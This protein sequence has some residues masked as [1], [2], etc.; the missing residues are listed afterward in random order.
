MSAPAA[1]TG[2]RIALEAKGVSK[3]FGATRALRDV[4]LELR[5][6]GIHAADSG[7][8]T[9]NGVE[10][11][12][13]AQT[14]EL[15]RQA[16]L[17]FVHQDPGIFPSMSLTENLSLGRGFER[18]AGRIDWAAAH[19]RARTVLAR[20]GITMDPTKPAAALSVP[21][22]AM[23]AIA[24]ALQDEDDEKG[25]ILI[26]DEPTA[27]LPATEVHILLEAIRKLAKAGHAILIVTHRLDEVRDVADRVTGFRDGEYVNTIDGEN[28]TEDVLVE[29]ILGRRLESA[30]SVGGGEVSTET[31]LE[32]EHVRGGPVVDVSLK[33]Q[34][35]EV[36]GIAG[37]LGAGRTELL[38]MIYGLLPVDSGTATYLGKQLKGHKPTDMCRQGMAFVP[39]D[40]GA[41]AVFPL[42]SV[43]EN[44]V[45]GHEMQYFRRF[46]I[47]DG[48]ERAE[49][50]ADVRRFGIRTSSISAKIES[51]SGGNQQKVI[52]AR[53]LREHPKLLLLDEPTQGVDV[54]ARDEIYKLIAL[55]A[56]EGC[57]VL[58]VSSEFEELARICGRVLVLSHGRIISEMKQPLLAHEILSESIGKREVL[59]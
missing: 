12:L 18:K 52:V 48:Q 57:A 20:F 43:L 28:L 21:Q 37:L 29:L 39:E 26:L 51:L 1:T 9:I 14:P 3:T 58:V 40:R 38:K 47:K 53:W 36:V 31:L 17:R 34:R 59:V 45:A 41:E 50:Q 19:R 11:D 42:A 25:G 7:T 27:A 35:G 33:I 32:L 44:L 56:D 6:A 10:M 4:R 24:R 5:L 30:A 23:L 46:W 55:A 8:V 22:R 2:Q 16:G 49:A 15:A 13:A 54:G